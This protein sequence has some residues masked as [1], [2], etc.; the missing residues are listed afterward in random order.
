MAD[1][2]W[3]MRLLGVT[4]GSRAPAVPH[5]SLD[6]RI[7]QGYQEASALTIRRNPLQGEH[8]LIHMHTVDCIH[9]VIPEREQHGSHL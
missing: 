9:Y 5:E 1:C 3:I 8:M 4:I 6:A 2:G 7:I